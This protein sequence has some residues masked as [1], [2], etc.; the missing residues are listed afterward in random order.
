[1]CAYLAVPMTSASSESVSSAV[2]NTVTNKRIRMSAGNVHNLALLHG[3]HGVRWNLGT[4]DAIEE[5]NK[6][7]IL[8]LPKKA[9][10][11]G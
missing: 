8:S 7:E 5:M 9:Q 10:K 4:S 3:C 11:V 2:D 6:Q 1:M